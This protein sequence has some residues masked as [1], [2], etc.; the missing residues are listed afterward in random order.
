VLSNNDGANSSII[1]RDVMAIY[2]GHG[3]QVPA[4]RTDAQIQPVR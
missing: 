2:Y 1:A 3:Y 4:V